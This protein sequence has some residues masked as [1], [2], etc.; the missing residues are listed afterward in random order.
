M[1]LSSLED[2]A[3][4]GG[5]MVVGVL[6]LAVFRGC[7]RVISSSLWHW[8]R[9]LSVGDVVRGDERTSESLSSAQTNSII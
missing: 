5:G 3:W 8:L 7:S 4:I 9:D 6:C 1:W 2:G